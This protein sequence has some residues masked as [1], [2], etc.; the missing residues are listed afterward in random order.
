VRPRLGSGVPDS[1]RKAARTES[2]AED[3]FV[4]AMNGALG[5]LTRSCSW[6]A[7]RPWHGTTRALVLLPQD[8]VPIVCEP[9]LGMYFHGSLVY[10]FERDE[11]PGHQG[12]TKVA[13]R[14][15]TYS[16]RIGATPDG[17]FAAWHWHPSTDV[18]HPHVHVRA[19]HPDV[20]GLRDMHL[21]T[22]RVFLEDVLI[23]A[24][25]DLGARCRDGDVVA[26]EALRDRTKAWASWR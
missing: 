22:A 13:I 10:A 11:R 15:Y 5:H 9:S 12:G 18:S 4:H 24:V 26:L 17:E 21:P 14:E 8:A 3:R 19:D 16:L 25:R 20:P 23:C 6:R 2:E 7:A 1:D